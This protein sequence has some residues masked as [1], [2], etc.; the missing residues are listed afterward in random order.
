[1]ILGYLGPEYTFSHK[2]ALSYLKRHQLNEN[3]GVQLKSADSFFNLFDWIKNQQCD[4]IIIPIENS[5]EGS[6]TSNLD[7]LAHLKSGI[8]VQEELIVEVDQNLIGCDLSNASEITDIF[9]HPQPIAQC[10]VYLHQNFKNMKTHESSSTTQAAYEILELSGNAQKQASFF[11][12]DQVHRLAVIGDIGLLAIAPNRLKLIT[13]K[14]SDF[15]NNQTRFFVL[16]T[17]QMPA[18]GTDKTSIIFSTQKDEPGGLYRILGEFAKRHINL[19]KIESRPT[20]EVLGE[21][22]FFIDFIGHISEGLTREALDAVQAQASFFKLL[23][24]YRV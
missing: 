5:I 20:K 10:Q 3:Q 24:S 18:T 16:G 1:M 17:E 4:Q 23:G 9:S 22:W 19:T 2:A 12:D 6:I 11:G 14:I 21:Y 8:F 15:P 7:S 13:K